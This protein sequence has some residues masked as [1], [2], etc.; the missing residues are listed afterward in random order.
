ML[1]T[2]PAARAWQGF[3]E[4]PLASALAA[5]AREPNSVALLDV[6]DEDAQGCARGPAPPPPGRGLPASDQPAAPGVKQ[7]PRQLH[8][9]R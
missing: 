4:V 9:T 6:R 3:Q 5:V 8:A 7:E 1:A 2:G